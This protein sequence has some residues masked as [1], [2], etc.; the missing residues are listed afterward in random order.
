MWIREFITLEEDEDPS[1][2]TRLWSAL[3]L[4]ASLWLRSYGGW[5]GLACQAYRAGQ[6]SL[7]FAPTLRMLRNAANKRELRKDSHVGKVHVCAPKV[8]T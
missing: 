4:T 1:V 2:P 5:G 6:I 3:S 8:V 7:W